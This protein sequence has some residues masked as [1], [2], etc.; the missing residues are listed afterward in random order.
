MNPLG[1]LPAGTPATATAPAT[2]LALRIDRILASHQRLWLRGCVEGL[3]PTSV[4]AR[5]WLGWKKTDGS[6]APPCLH[7]Q[8]QVSGHTLEAE[9]PV[10][11]DGSW[12]ASFEARLP[13]ARRGWRV[14]RNRVTWFE[15]H[16][17]CCAVVAE[18]PASTVGVILV[19]LPPT[20]TTDG[21][22]DDRAIRRFGQT[23]QRLRQG[24]HGG[25]AFY[26][27]ARHA[28]AQEFPAAELAL[29]LTAAGWPVGPILRYRDGELP[30]MLDR[31]RW[32]FAG[33]FDLQ[34]YDLDPAAEPL[35]AYLADAPERAAVRIASN[36]FKPAAADPTTEPG[37]AARHLPGPLGSRSAL[38]TRYPL[39]F[40]HGMLACSMLRMQLAKNSNYFAILQNHFESRGFRVLFP[41]VPP[42]GGVVERAE[43]LRKQIRHWTDEPVNLIAHSMGGLDARYLITHLQMAHQV[44]SLTTISTPHRGTYVAD[45]F[46]ANYRR[47]VPLL[48]ALEA[49]GINVDGFRDCQLAVC[50]A[51]NE[52]TPDMP[53][54]RYFSY[55][56][57]V[58]QTRVTPML[59]RGWAMLKAVEGPNDGLVSLASARWGEYLGTLYADHFA[60]CPDGLFVHPK[61]TFDSVGFLLRLVENLAR[62]G[63]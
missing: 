47:R 28:T 34:L 6:E 4:P 22:A 46:I 38:L 48:L 19:L 20:V 30:T 10:A 60:Q 40:C 32:L 23:L 21:W 61:E 1:F 44:R 52:R 53:G 26:Y 58:P 11:A 50:K 9:V 55:G 5:R 41:M 51:F 63:L 13:P 18:P 15:Q 54:V 16:A 7:L 37:Q 56:G 39:V 57:D 62:R 45:W 36:P 33:E 43:E 17:E 59:R 42:T 29:A 2:P 35:D 14:A 49:L 24:P 12:Q 27:L 3:P 31:L 25:H 8:T